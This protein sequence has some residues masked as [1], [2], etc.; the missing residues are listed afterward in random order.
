MSIYSFLT[1]CLSSFSS[2]PPSGATAAAGV[3]LPADAA[4]AGPPAAAV[5]LFPCPDPL[6]PAL[7]LSAAHQQP[8]ARRPEPGPR[9]HNSQP[10]PGAAA[11]T[12]R[13]TRLGS[14]EAAA[15]REGSGRRR[16]GDDMTAETLSSFSFFR[17]LFFFSLFKKYAEI[18]GN[19]PVGQLCS[20]AMRILAAEK[21]VPG[22]FFFPV[23]C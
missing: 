17:F 15:G 18:S 13:H 10:L 20:P 7:L 4:A 5:A 2:V 21:S 16:A 19:L 9:H 12:C 1:S 11:H 8:A 22:T 3:A 14:T 23:V 6:H